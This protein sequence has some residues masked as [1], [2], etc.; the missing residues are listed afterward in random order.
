MLAGI[1]GSK[2][3]ASCC[4]TCSSRSPPAPAEEALADGDLA[5]EA[6]EGDV[7]DGAAR[8]GG[9]ELGVLRGGE[10]HAGSGARPAARVTRRAARPQ[11]AT[12]RTPAHEAPMIFR[13]R[14]D[15]GRRLAFALRPVWASG[16]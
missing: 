3:V 9:D 10:A 1:S 6:D 14:V 7:E 13:D 5:G 12:R 15:A 11:V 2:H 16:R 4:Q 8:Q